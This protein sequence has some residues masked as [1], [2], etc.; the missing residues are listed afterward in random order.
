MISCKKPTIYELV[1]IQ[2][3][4]YMMQLSEDNN[5]HLPW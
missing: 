4:F 2:I 3:Q 1:V 5:M